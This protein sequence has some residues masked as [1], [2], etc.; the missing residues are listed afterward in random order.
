[1]WKHLELWIQF[2]AVLSSAPSK[3]VLWN[4]F[5]DLSMVLIKGKL[6][7]IEYYFGEYLK[8]FED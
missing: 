3:C 6:G 2:R 1:M 7:L 8:N 5:P 4:Y